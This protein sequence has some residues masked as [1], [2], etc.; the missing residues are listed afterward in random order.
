MKLKRLSIGIVFSLFLVNIFSLT[1]FAP[2]SAGAW[3]N[4]SSVSADHPTDSIN[5]YQKYWSLYWCMQ[6]G[7]AV[8]GEFGSVTTD[9]LESGDIF[10]SGR[11]YQ[12]N[13]LNNNNNGKLSCSGNS[14]AL[15]S[16]AG[17]FPGDD[18]RGIIDFFTEPYNFGGGPAGDRPPLYIPDGEGTGEY[19]L[20]DGVE[21]S[22]SDSDAWNLISRSLTNRHP[23]INF[24]DTTMPGYAQY[25]IARDTFI[26]K[27]LVRVDQTG[28]QTVRIVNNDGTEIPEP[29]NKFVIDTSDESAVRTGHHVGYGMGGRGA[30]D[31]RE[32]STL[33]CS[34]MVDVLNN[35]ADSAIAALN[36]YLEANPDA[37]PENEGIDAPEE[38][39]G[40][41]CEE[42]GGMAW[43]F[44]AV[45][46]V[47]SSALES[48]DTQ[49]ASLLS[50]DGDFFGNDDL[51]SA[52]VVLRNIA[53][54]L[55][56]PAM[57]VMIISTALGFDFVS[58]YTVKTAL[59]RMVI[60]TIFIALSYDVTVFAV[61]IVQS[62]GY[63]I[64][65]ILLSPF[66]APPYNLDSGSTMVNHLPPLPGGSGTQT[67]LSGLAGWGAFAAGSAVFGGGFIATIAGFAGLA[68]LALLVVLTLLLLRQ[69]LIV[70]LVLVSPI[71]ILAW[72]FPGRTTV[73][74]VW[75]KT[76]WLMMWFFPIIMATTAVGKIMAV[77]ISQGTVL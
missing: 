20:N 25:F 33:Y 32:G 21:N 70:L 76:F 8:R 35:N 15:L 69:T 14:A 5:D 12:G 47:A 65:N 67:G 42:G 38:D 17:I 56:V 62:V 54:T 18:E 36:S 40:P 16:Y 23:E 43:L 72:I 26:E 58:A 59:P 63:G 19:R 10:F 13:H 51:R 53:Y 73:W 52:W 24:T 55:L 30:D 60:A 22:S 7:Q 71:A 34:T 28:G 45:L 29:D 66:N 4:A 39:T 74:S 46:R 57:L 3:P 49:M 31:R 44:C 9:E 68:A 48:V 27:C 11:Q 77:L 1:V 41:T 37:D 6:G 64:H 2:N 50:I 75:N 61:D